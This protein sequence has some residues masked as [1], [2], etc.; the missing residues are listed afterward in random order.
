VAR[1]WQ[2]DHDDSPL[3][4]SLRHADCIG[5]RLHHCLVRHSPYRQHSSLFNFMAAIYRYQWRVLSFYWFMREPYPA[6]DFTS[7]DVDTGTDPA[8]L[9]SRIPTGSAPLLLVQINRSA[10]REKH[11]ASL[12]S[13]SKSA[14]RVAGRA[15]SVSGRGSAS[16]WLEGRGAVLIGRSTRSGVSGEVVACRA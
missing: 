8:A 13:E 9:R 5:V 2:S 10:S 16:A 6:F 7:S 1:D 11:V 4:R 12:L 3:D 15:S 14:A